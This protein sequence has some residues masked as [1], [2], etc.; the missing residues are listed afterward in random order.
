MEPNWTPHLAS[1]ALSIHH[2]SELHVFRKGWMSPRCS[3]HLRSALLC[4]P[5]CLKLSAYMKSSHFLLV[6]LFLKVAMWD[7]KLVHVTVR[8][9]VQGAHS[10]PGEQ[11]DFSAPF[12]PAVFFLLF[13]PFCCPPYALL[14]L[15]SSSPPPFLQAL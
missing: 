13:T 10:G 11:M 5:R 12:K 9:G 6:P 2:C 1:S 7:N 8:I 14:A 15:I 3:A 4:S